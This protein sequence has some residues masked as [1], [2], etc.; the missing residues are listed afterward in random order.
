M[1]FLAAIESERKGTGSTPAKIAAPARKVSVPSSNTFRTTSANSKPVSS[2]RRDARALNGLS[3]SP[4]SVGL[5]LVQLQRQCGNGY[6]QRVINLAEASL[7]ASPSARMVQ[8][9]DDGADEN[10]QSPAS[11]YVSLDEDLFVEDGQDNDG[12]AAASGPPVLVQRAPDGQDIPPPPPAFPSVSEWAFDVFDDAGSLYG[13]TCEDRRE[14]GFV[15]MWNERTNTSF[16]GPTAIGD[17]TVGCSTRAHIDLV[18]PADRP[19]LF[20]V[21]WFHTHPP[22]NP[23]CR[24]LAVGP[25]DKDKK[26]SERLGLPGMVIDTATPTADCKTSSYFFF[27]PARRTAAG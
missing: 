4:A 20:P 26:T 27:G 5:Y 23:G 8:R 7:A 2:A 24:K 3:G 17:P 22:A 14:R 16:A 18:F 25:S 12:V 15:T 19:P 6:V 9:Q 1:P 21:G 11:S 13:L 10:S